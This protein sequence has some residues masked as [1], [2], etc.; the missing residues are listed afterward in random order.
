[1]KSYYVVI[2]RWD[3]FGT[4]ERRSFIRN[5]QNDKELIDSISDDY[6]GYIITFFKELD[7]VYD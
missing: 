6:S 4:S 2:E 7:A 3:G 5:K 1:M